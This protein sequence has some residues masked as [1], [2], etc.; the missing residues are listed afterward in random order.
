MCKR[1]LNNNENEKKNDSGFH[2]SV[3]LSAD[4]RSVV[5]RVVG[6]KTDMGESDFFSRFFQSY[7]F[8]HI[9]LTV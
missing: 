9:S 7:P 1:L 4:S 5:K 8:Y 2:G 3:S 6:L